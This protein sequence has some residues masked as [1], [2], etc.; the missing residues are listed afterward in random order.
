MLSPEVYAV[1]ETLLKGSEL[2]AIVIIM[3]S[4]NL[5]KGLTR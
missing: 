4:K 3:T 5:I 2:E 1:F